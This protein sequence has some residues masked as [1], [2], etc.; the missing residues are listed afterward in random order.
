MASTK[1]WSTS[2]NLKLL[3][4]HFL[5]GLHSSTESL[6]IALL[7]LKDPHKQ[8]QY[9]TFQT[10]RELSNNLFKC[11]ESLLPSNQWNQISRLSVATGPGGFTSTRITIAMCR[12]LAQ[13]LK[14]ELDGISSFALMA[15]RLHTKENLQK[16]YQPFWI[17]SSLVKRGL[18]G[19]LYLIKSDKSLSYCNRLLEIQTPHLLT[20][21]IDNHP[22]LKAEEN[23]ESDT[24]E[25]MRIS[26]SAHEINK[27]SP[28]ESVV[29]IYPTSPVDN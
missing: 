28:W 29:P 18:V 2:S 17:T 3:T 27:K 13:Q 25:L 22:T 26:L 4:K 10:G 12:T 15:N 7:D 20:N 21:K 14:C 6:G 8:I 11:I 1:T 24:L 5:L 19:G 23:I 9:S 16:L